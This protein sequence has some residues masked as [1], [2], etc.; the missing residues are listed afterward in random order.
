[1]LDF[2]INLGKVRDLLTHP[3]IKRSESRGSYSERLDPVELYPKALPNCEENASNETCD[4]TI[5]NPKVKESA[6]VNIAMDNDLLEPSSSESMHQP[7]F[8]VDGPY[9]TPMQDI[10]RYNTSLC[11]AGGIGITPYAAVL[12]MIRLVPSL[13][14]CRTYILTIADR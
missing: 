11:V 8:Y 4:R 2:A 9:G 1:M 14:I 10:F 5:S 12:N 7:R 6:D 3:H 13:S